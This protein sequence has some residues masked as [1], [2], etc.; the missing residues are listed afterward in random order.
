MKEVR[1]ESLILSQNQLECIEILN[2]GK[3]PIPRFNNL[4]SGF[5]LE[6][7]IAEARKRVYQAIVK[8]GLEVRNLKAYFTTVLKRLVY[9]ELEKHYPVPFVGLD[10]DTR[11]AGYL[12]KF[13]VDPK[14]LG[15]M[16]E[17]VNTRLLFDKFVVNMAKLSK[18]QKTLIGYWLLEIP[19]EI[20]AA[21]THQPLEKLEIEMQ[22]A[23]STWRRELK[24]IMKRR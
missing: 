24:R 11:P 22:K 14:A 10:D 9:D 8:K 2:S 15:R 12:D 23:L 13:L 4:P 17:D 5:D 3:L 20:I 21:R 16:I 18:R 7:L 19:K 1:D 6:N